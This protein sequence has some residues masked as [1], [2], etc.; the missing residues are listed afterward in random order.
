LSLRPNGPTERSP[1]M[2]PKADSL[3]LRAAPTSHGL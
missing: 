2:R 3:G 1:G